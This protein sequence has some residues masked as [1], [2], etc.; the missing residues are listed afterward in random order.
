VRAYATGEVERCFTNDVEL[1]D[2]RYVRTPLDG[3]PRVAVLDATQDTLILHERFATGELVS[4]NELRGGRI[5]WRINCESEDEARSWA[6][7]RA[8]QRVASGSWPPRT[9]SD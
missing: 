4:Y 8:S 2:E 9:S 3:R 6:R 5:A 1:L 7:R